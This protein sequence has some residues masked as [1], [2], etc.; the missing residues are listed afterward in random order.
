MKFLS[1][2]INKKGIPF[3]RNKDIRNS[4]PSNVKTDVII[5]QLNTDRRNYFPSK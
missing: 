3:Q 5:F 2:E 4:F 1:N